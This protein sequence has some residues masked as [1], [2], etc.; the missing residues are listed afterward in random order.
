[1]NE[2]IAQLY[3][4]KSVR[5][6]QDRRID[7]GTKDELIDAALQAPTA[8]NQILYTILDIEDQALKDALAETCDNQPFIAAAPVVF[9]F[10]ADCRRWLDAYRYAGAEARDPGL[11]DA[12][13]SCADALIAAQNLVTAAESMG[14]GSCYI[15]DILENRE[16]V[17]ELLKLDEYT[18]PAAMLVLG[19]PT[20]QQRARPKPVRFDRKYI[21][22]KNAYSRLGETEIREMFQAAREDEAFDYDRFIAAFCARKYMSD[23]A[24]EMN[25]SAEGYLA[26]FRKR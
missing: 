11:G 17:S 20:D 13:L 2:T 10:L 23:F 19:Y 4:R 16:R 24:A 14:I 21:V 9:V 3:G 26:A 6:F 8:G 22:R 25:R 5:A 1:M 12:L 18:F 15:G 7:Q